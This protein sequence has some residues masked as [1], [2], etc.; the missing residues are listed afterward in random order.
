MTAKVLES[1]STP[2]M[3]VKLTPL[4]KRR[5][6]VISPILQHGVGSEAGHSPEPIIPIKLKAK[7]GKVC[8]I[9]CL[10][11]STNNHL[12]VAST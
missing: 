1:P 5:R 6:V 8:L 9:C 4:S 12:Y 11:Q 10:I 3:R 7:P 2:K